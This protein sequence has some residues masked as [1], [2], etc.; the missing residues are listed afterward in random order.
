MHEL[1]LATALINGLRSI[2]GITVYGPTDPAQCTAVIACR[3]EGKRVSEIGLRLNE[4]LEILC[5]VGLHCGPVAHKT[6]GTFPE[7]TV[8]LAPG[9]FTTMDDIGA[10]IAA[11][12]ELARR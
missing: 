10:T 12:K 8:R 11:F 1:E 3:V 4:E 6:I 5:G 2:P 9:P 7:G